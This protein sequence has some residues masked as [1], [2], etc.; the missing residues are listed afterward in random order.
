MIDAVRKVI[1]AYHDAPLEFCRRCDLETEGIRVDGGLHGTPD[2]D[3]AIEEL[4]GILK[5]VDE[6]TKAWFAL[7]PGVRDE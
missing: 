2:L 6:V 7:R 1:A 5:V 3:T 4:E